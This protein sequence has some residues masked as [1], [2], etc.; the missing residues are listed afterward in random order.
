MSSDPA[1]FSLITPKSDKFSVIQSNNWYSYCSN[2]PV[3]FIDPTGL[4]DEDTNTIQY[5]DTLNKIAEQTGKDVDSLMELNPQITDKDKIFAGDIL[6]LE[7]D[8]DTTGDTTITHKIDNSDL[9]DDDFT[10]A[11]AIIQGT[12]GVL[13]MIAAGGVLYLVSQYRP[14]AIEAGGFLATIIS[15]D[16]AAR[17]YDA[18]RGKRR[19]ME[20][21]KEQAKTLFDA[22]FIDSHVTAAEAFERRYVR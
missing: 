12:V 20:E 13:E 21:V 1:G 11:D 8:N 15:A 22:L 19:D 2:N 17:L 10:R 14:E 18:N 16:G 5:G 3:R 4:F 7:P 9:A 6:K